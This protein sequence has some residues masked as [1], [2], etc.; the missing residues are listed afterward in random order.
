MAL[1][2]FVFTTLGPVASIE[3]AN[4][5]P[6][7]NAKPDSQEAIRVKVKGLRSDKGQILVA[8]F[9]QKRGFPGKPEKAIKKQVAKVEKKKA[10]FELT[11]LKPGTYAIVVV[12]DENGNNEMDKSFIGIPKEGFGTSNNVLNKFGPPRYSKARFEY[13]GGRHSLTIKMEYY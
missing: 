13:K 7:A 3:N 6:K 5:N 4:A 1:I 11:Q 12:H 8:V 9:N 2:C 10:I